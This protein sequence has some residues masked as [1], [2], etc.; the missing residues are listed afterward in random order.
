MSRGIDD[1]S[2]GGG[3]GDCDG[4]LG[5]SDGSGDMVMIALGSGGDSSSS[6]VDCS[7]S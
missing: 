6:L 7:L 4:N 3:G 1:C 5:Y 2:G